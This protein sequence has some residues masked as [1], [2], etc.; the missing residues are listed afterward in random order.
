MEIN[1]KY[2]STEAFQKFSSVCL[3]NPIIFVL[4]K[5]NSKD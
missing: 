1:N 5:Q 3:N 2:I 4:K